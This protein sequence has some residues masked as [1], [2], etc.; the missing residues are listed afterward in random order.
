MIYKYFLFDIPK[1]LD[2]CV[3]YK[4][5][6]VLEKLIENLFNSQKNYFDDF[7][8]C[9]KDIIKAIETSKKKLRSI[10]DLDS[11]YEFIQ[12]NSTK[13][14]DINNKIKKNL[15]EILEIIYYLTDFVRTLIDLISIQTKLAEYLFDQKFE[16][17]IKDIMESTLFEIEDIVYKMKKNQENDYRF[18]FFIKKFIK[19]IL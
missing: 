14:K 16:L 19:I 2:L 6:P 10:F 1:I 12:N 4:N 8:H 17:N 7:K 5:N 18:K 9:I 3:L 11:I 15:K 13:E